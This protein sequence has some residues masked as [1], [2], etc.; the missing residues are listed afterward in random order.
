VNLSQLRA[1]LGVAE[2]KGFSA[3]VGALHTVQSNV[4]SDIANL[5]MELGAPLVERRG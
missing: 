2:D 4:S 3:A 5:E 1:V